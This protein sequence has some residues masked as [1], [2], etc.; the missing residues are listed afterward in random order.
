[1]NSLFPLFSLSSLV[2]KLFYPRNENIPE[3]RNSTVRLQNYKQFQMRELSQKKDR[4]YPKSQ[5]V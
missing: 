1:M 2:F 4:E 5:E 3:K